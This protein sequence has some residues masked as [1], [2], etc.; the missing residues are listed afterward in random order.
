M[1]KRIIFSILYLLIYSGLSIAESDMSGKHAAM[2]MGKKKEIASATLST[3]VTV[4]SSGKSREAGFDGRYAMEP[5]SVKADP[6]EKCA[7][8]SRGIIILDRV[9]MQKC[10]LQSNSMIKKT[11]HSGRKQMDHSMP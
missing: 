5:T 6:G 8:A 7:L 10:G 9:N 3:L 1:K 4:P 2:D 11:E